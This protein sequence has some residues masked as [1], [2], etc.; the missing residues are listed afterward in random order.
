MK[1]ILD[2]PERIVIEDRPWALGLFLIAAVLASL[3]MMFTA[4]RGEGIGLLAAAALLFL[5]SALWLRHGIRHVRLTLL[6]DG[7][8]HLAI[9]AF[10]GMSTHD[11]APGALRAAVQSDRDGEGVTTRVML[12]IDGS[13]GVERL[14]LTGYY[15]SGSGPETVVRR[16]VEWRGAILDTGSPTD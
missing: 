5:G 16:I 6:P 2:T 10:S 4:L 9:R 8:A 12:L 7:S 3:H 13:D 11:F 15:T 14:P 1:I